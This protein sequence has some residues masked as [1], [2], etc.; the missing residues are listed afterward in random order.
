MKSIRK[1]LNHY[2]FTI[3]PLAALL[4]AV[5][6]ACLPAQAQTI[7]HVGGQNAIGSTT[8]ATVAG[9]G[10]VTN[11]VDSGA[12]WVTAGGAGVVY[13]DLISPTLTVATAGQVTLKFKHRYNFEPDWD[14]GA[15]YV[16]VN[17]SGP[18]YVPL[19]AFTANGYNAN[20]TSSS[21]F[22]A[23][24]V[25]NAKSTGYDTS[26]LIESVVN[27]G[28]F[29]VNDTIAITFKGGWDEGVSPPDPNWEIGTVEVRDS[30]STAMLN[31][32]FVNG[33][34]GFTVVSDP[35]LAGPWRYPGTVILS[36][37]EI[38]GDTLAA[39]KYVPDILGSIIDLNNA[40]LEV[41]LLAGTIEVGDTFT[42]FDLSGG[43]SLSGNYGSIVL[44]KVMTPVGLVAAVWDTTQLSAGG[45]ATITCLSIPNVSF[46]QTDLN[47][48]ANSTGSEIQNDGMLIR[49][50]H[51]GQ[52]SRATTV[53][54]VTFEQGTGGAVNDSAFSYTLSSP[55]ADWLTGQ[56][57]VPIADANWNE[58][59][60]RAYVGGG[61]FTITVP[62][63]VVGHMYRLQ[64]L[65][66]RP[67][68]GTP[69]VEGASGDPFPA[70]DPRPN[71]RLITA[72]WIAE[73]DTMDMAFD[74][75]SPGASSHYTG[76]AL[77]D[78]TP[79]AQA[80]M[81]SFT[82]PIQGAATI[83]GNDIRI[84]VPRATDITALS[85]TYTTSPGA[86]CTPASS[87]QQNFSAG[88]VYYEVVSQDTT[89]TNIYNVVVTKEGGDQ[90][91]MTS[92]TF[93]GLGNATISG[94][95]I[96]L[97]VPASTSLTALSPTYAT[98][99]YANSTPASGS[100]HDFS[101]GAVYY[102]V[103]SENT[104]L[105]NIYNVV[106]TK[107][108]P[109][110]FNVNLGNVA[111]N[112]LNG[113]AYMTGGYAQAPY[114]YSGTVWAE[115]SVSPDAKSALL[116]SQGNVTPAGYTTVSANAAPAMQA[117]VN[118][119]DHPNVPLLQAGVTRNYNSGSGLA[120]NNRFTVTGLDPANTY[121]IFVVGCQQDNANVMEWGLGAATTPPSVTKFI[122]NTLALH[123]NWVAGDNYAVLYRAVPDANG[124]IYVWGRSVTSDS[125]KGGLTLN[126]FQVVDGSLIQ[127]PE[128]DMLSCSFG[129]LGAASISGNQ[130]SLTVTYRTDVTAL[131]PAITVSSGAT[132]SPTGPQNFTSPVQYT[133]TAQDGS[134]KAYTVT[135]NKLPFGT[136]NVGNP[137]FEKFAALAHGTWGGIT[138]P[139][140]SQV[141][142][143]W[144]FYDDRCGINQNG[145]PWF[146]AS[147]APAPNGSYAAYLQKSTTSE[148]RWVAQSLY[149]EEAGDYRVSFAVIGR[150]IDGLDFSTELDVLIDDVPVLSLAATDI[151][152]TAWVN[153]TSTVFT[154]TAG[155]THTLKFATAG[156]TGDAD[157]IDT[158]SVNYVGVV[159]P[160][161]PTLPV[162][163]FTPS[164]VPTFANVPTVNG[165]TYWL[166]YKDDLSAGGSWT[167]IGTGWRSDGSEHTFGDST[168]PLP[169][170][171]FYRLEVQ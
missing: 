95:D 89:V 81:N 98:S 36:Q 78:I 87:S 86:T 42:L 61:S 117:P 17:G 18:T 115:S 52:I 140:D 22:A 157:A 158:V 65:W 50:Y 123:D 12:H 29:N 150:T 32:D 23:M 47:V 97:K 27:L 49:A 160:P 73:D 55:N 82:F 38:N 156:L 137:S 159:P 126:G 67:N 75:A 161:Q 146:D 94:L 106:V 13:S 170:L 39:D 40:N 167:R 80:N 54:G 108:V 125:S 111:G 84:T 5:V 60:N 96:R 19:S 105:T 121:H 133:V 21:V 25:F 68:D 24:D 138:S 30:A 33:P 163:S 62:N 43:S 2:C 48:A 116:D 120:M 119:A 112:T 166:T 154:V 151:G 103:I 3:R 145:G 58:L 14:G 1:T 93:P 46:T 45:T 10:T 129:S 100:T 64:L 134:T 85:P 51:F 34:A 9:V 70:S 147:I 83:S 113:R 165:Y 135:I 72:K 142:W 71:P 162:G 110:V 152:N 77:H 31:V 169:A 76:Y 90:A 57:G 44:P 122:T 124:K 153:K 92:F 41:V 11:T 63:L 148:I 141:V 107:D 91:L 131:T 8:L 69:S 109:H 171:R 104:L 56:T 128:K 4:A 88:K 7:F 35:A 66:M 168:S 155:S 114:A 136:V 15:V 144:A 20:L 28:T 79:A 99:S 118:W 143:A 16:D 149:F 37:F 132:A 53:N 130:V 6:W 26:T 74:H 139:S 102:T 101:L 59:I 164:P 127:S